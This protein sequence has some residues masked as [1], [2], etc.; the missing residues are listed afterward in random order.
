MTITQTQYY[1]IIIIISMAVHALYC[2]HARRTDKPYII[3]KHLLIRVT[4]AVSPV[5]IRDTCHQQNWLSAKHHFE[6]GGNWYGQKL[7]VYP[8]Y[9]SHWKMVQ[10]SAYVRNMNVSEQK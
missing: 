10:Q 2:T 3:V 6:K 1:V 4:G 7:Y 9:I 5:F 8:T